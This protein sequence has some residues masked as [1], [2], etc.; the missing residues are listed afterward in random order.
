MRAR[1]MDPITGRFISEDPAKD[2]GNWYTYCD[3]NVTNQVDP[4][5][6]FVEDVIKAERDVATL[7][8]AQGKIAQAY[9]MAMGKLIGAIVGAESLT[10]SFNMKTSQMF[11]NIVMN[12]REV[13][14]RLDLSGHGGYPAHINTWIKP[15][16]PGH[17]IFLDSIETL[18]DKLSA[19]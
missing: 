15:G 17:M 10:V 8:W 14:V 1:W 2:G 16:Q 12:G 3:N 13:V 18:I 9:G 6:L 5:G 4:T 11:Y 19:L 7:G